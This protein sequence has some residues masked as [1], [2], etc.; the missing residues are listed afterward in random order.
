MAWTIKLLVIANRTADSDELR[1]ALVERAQRGPLRVTLLAPATPEP[2]DS[3]SAREVT[4]QRLEAAVARLRAEGLEVEGIVGDADPM[5]ALAD[6]WDPRR[7]H[8]IIVC[9]LPA[10]TSRWLRHD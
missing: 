8:E 3:R 4:R 5:M 1:A 2:G 10:A 6:V 9:T 7:F